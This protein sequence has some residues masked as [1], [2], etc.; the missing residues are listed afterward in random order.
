MTNVAGI[1]S[2]KSRDQLFASLKAEIARLEAGM[3]HANAE[4]RK[5]STQPSPDFEEIGALKQAVIQLRVRLIET[6]DDLADAEEG[7][8][9]R[10]GA[11]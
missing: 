7:H 5:L 3:Q 9:Q 4:L 6:R 10:R 2:P 1:A 11:G 8:F